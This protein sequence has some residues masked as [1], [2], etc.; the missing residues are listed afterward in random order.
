MEVTTDTGHEI[1]AR[2]LMHI[3]LYDN[4][5]VNRFEPDTKSKYPK[6]HFDAIVRACELFFDNHPEFLTDDDLDNI[7]A[8]ELTENQEKYGIFPEYQAIDLALNSYFDIM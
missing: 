7:A 1:T 4:G 3:M 6:T 5:A 2:K 8:G